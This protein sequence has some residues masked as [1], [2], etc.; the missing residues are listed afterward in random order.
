MRKDKM[1][2]ERNA[3]SVRLML[4]HNE[5][6]DMIA[7]ILGDCAT[8]GGINADITVSDRFVAVPPTSWSVCVTDCGEDYIDDVQKKALFVRPVDIRSFENFVD[9]VAREKCKPP[10]GTANQEKQ[11]VYIDTATRMIRR[12][13]S[14]AVLT[15]REY[16]LFSALVSANGDIVTREELERIVWKESENST[17]VVDVYIA[18]LRKKL[19]R[20]FGAELIITVRGKGYMIADGIYTNGNA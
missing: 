8:D 6:Y 20:A 2:R 19:R 15:K 7:A 4:D 9:A 16:A 18:Y 5:I 13:D 12:G 3:L 1:I 14:A 17:N 10:S 11:D